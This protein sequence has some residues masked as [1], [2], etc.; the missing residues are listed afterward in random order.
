SATA[1]RASYQTARG[2]A[3]GVSDPKGSLRHRRPDPVQANLDLALGGTPQ[4]DDAA[5]RRAAASQDAQFRQVSDGARYADAAFQELLQSVPETR[6]IERNSSV[7]SKT[8][9]RNGSP[10]DSPCWCASM[11][12]WTNDWARR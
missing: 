2:T 1:L 3:S 12:F 4:R 6:H 9:D 7:A 8:P 5:A 11:I 10:R